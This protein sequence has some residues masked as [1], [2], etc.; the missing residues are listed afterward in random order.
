MQLAGEMMSCESTNCVAHHLQLCI[1]EELSITA[2]SQAIS[3]ARK[4]VGHFCHSVLTTNALHR[5]Q[6]DMGTNPKKLQQDCPTRWN[7]TNYM[8]KSLLHSRR[9]TGTHG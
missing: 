7:S 2:I 5:Y 8:S 3:A 4:L 6:E 1:E 9:H